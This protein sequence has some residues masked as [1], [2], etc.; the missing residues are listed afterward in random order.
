[1]CLTASTRKSWR[2]PHPRPRRDR[3]NSNTCIDVS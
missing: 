3:R 2:L 1:M